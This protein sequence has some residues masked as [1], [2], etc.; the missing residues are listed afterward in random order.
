MLPPRRW[1]DPEALRL[2]VCI[3]QFIIILVPLRYSNGYSS[4]FFLGGFQDIPISGCFF[5]SSREGF[6]PSLD[7]AKA[8]SQ[9]LSFWRSLAHFLPSSVA[10]MIG[11]GTLMVIY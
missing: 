4:F 10:G 6:R 8:F 5:T 11:T 2:G 9:S 3:A 7:A 1:C